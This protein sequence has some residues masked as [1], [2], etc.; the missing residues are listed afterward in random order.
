MQFN[1]I[2]SPVY[3]AVTAFA[4][5]P[6]GTISA[7]YVIGTGTDNDGQVTDFTPL[8]TEYK[9]LDQEQSQQIFM[10]PM[11]KEDIGKPFQD[12]ML[13]KIYSYLRENNL[14]QA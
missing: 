1:K 10:A 14:V 9:Y 7:T 3:S 11:K 6:D 4:M 5:N 2:L 8:V 12:L 13:G